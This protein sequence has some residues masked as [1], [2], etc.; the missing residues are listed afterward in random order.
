[1]ERSVIRGLSILMTVVV[2]FGCGKKNPNLPDL[3]PVTGTVTLDGK[4]LDG[5]TVYFTPVGDTR[6]VDAFGK[7][8]SQGRY[9]L[10][11]RKMGKGTPIGQ[12]KVTIGK[13]VMLDGSSAEG[14]A[15][16]PDINPRREILPAK[17]SHPMATI[18]RATIAEGGSEIDFPLTTK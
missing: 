16:D 6:G 12:Y 1:M 18:L 14:K 8:D 7:T 17:Y 10:G 11:S 9:T 5:A 3:V 2:V 4:P 13:T 15:T